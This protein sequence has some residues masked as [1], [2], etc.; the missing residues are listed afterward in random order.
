MFELVCD[1]L[2]FFMKLLPLLL[3]TV[4]PLPS[5]PLQSVSCG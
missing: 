1:R 4:L 3:S 2:N 5:T